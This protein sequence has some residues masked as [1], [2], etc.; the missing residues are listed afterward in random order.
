MNKKDLF[1]IRYEKLFLRIGW[2]IAS[3]I[4]LHL[5]ADDLPRCRDWVRANLVEEG[6]GIWLDSHETQVMTLNIDGKLDSML[7][8]GPDE[9][10]VLLTAADVKWPKKERNKKDDSRTH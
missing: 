4:P 10:E 5:D 8:T 6:C 7:A 1:I 9:D 3:P 2:Y